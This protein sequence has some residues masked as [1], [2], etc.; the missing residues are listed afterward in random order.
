MKIKYWVL[1]VNTL[2][3][4]LVGRKQFVQIKKTKNKL[5]AIKT[6]ASQSFVLEPHLFLFFIND[7]TSVLN[8][9]GKLYSLNMLQLFYI[10]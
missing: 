10:V 8:L 9:T 4:Y 5:V 7:M 3:S 6:G 1:T 2:E